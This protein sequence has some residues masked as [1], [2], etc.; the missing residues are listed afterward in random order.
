MNRLFDAYCITVADRYERQRQA[1]LN[2]AWEYCELMEAREQQLAFA[3]SEPAPTFVAY[4]QIIEGG[5]YES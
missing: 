1:A 4:G 2:A 5:G 3:L